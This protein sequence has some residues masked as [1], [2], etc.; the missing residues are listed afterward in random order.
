MYKIYIRPIHL[1]V[2]DCSSW[3]H[4][5]DEGVNRSV[6]QKI[7]DHVNNALHIFFLSVYWSVYHWQKSKAITNTYSGYNALEKYWKGDVLYIS[8]IL[9]LGNWPFRSCSIL[10]KASRTTSIYFAKHG[11]SNYSASYRSHRSIRQSN[12][13]DFLNIITCDDGKSNTYHYFFLH[14]HVS[15]SLIYCFS[16]H[17]FTRTH[18]GLVLWSSFQ[19]KGCY[20]SWQCS[21][22]VPHLRRLSVLRDREPVPMPYT[23]WFEFW[24]ATMLLGEA[25][26]LVPCRNCLVR[27]YYCL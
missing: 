16:C 4:S 14:T 18:F 3:N 1:C 13:P 17:Y 6:L 5:D 26:S 25:F 9:W 23:T 21:H 19:P 7:L 2:C 24:N 22:V 12:M 11:F 20:F 8:L 10:V 15:S 27:R